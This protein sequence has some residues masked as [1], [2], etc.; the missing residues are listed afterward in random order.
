MEL[1]F[2]KC[3]VKDAEVL[4][5]F[6]AQ[7]YF[8]TFAP[9]NTPEVMAA[10]LKHA[11]AEEKIRSELLDENSAFY[12]LYSGAELAGYLKLNEAPSQTDI[13]DANSLELERIYVAAAFQHAGI[14]QVLMDKAVAV[15]GQRGKKYLWLGVWQKN[16]KAIR[17]YE[18]NGFYKTGTHIFV[19]GDEEQTDYVMRKDL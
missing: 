6:A 17:F 2:K 3:T 19:M 1:T 18:R 8:E 12:F 10:Y 7:I 5:K 15:A 14:G 4:R 13:N 11:F 9:L 16:E